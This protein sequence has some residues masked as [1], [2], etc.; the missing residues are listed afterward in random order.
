LLAVVLCA[1]SVSTLEANFLAK[2]GRHRSP[3]KDSQ[4]VLPSVSRK[5]NQKSYA[6]CDRKCGHWAVFSL[7]SNALYSVVAKARTDADCLVAETRS[8]VNR[9]SLTSTKALR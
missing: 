3:P 4:A 1:Y 2:S 9:R 7:N 6:Y 8:L 5:P